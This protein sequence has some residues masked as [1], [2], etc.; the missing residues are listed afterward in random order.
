[1][2]KLVVNLDPQVNEVREQY[3][4]YYARQRELA[5]EQ[6]GGLMDDV[7]YEEGQLGE[8]FFDDAKEYIKTRYRK[9]PSILRAG[10][11]AA[12]R[13]GL[14]GLRGIAG[15]FAQGMNVREAAKKRLAGASSLLRTMMGGRRRRRA[16][17]G[18]R[19]GGINK[20]LLAKLKL[21]CS[22]RKR[23]RGRVTKRRRPRKVCRKRKTTRKGGC[24]KTTR[25]RR[26]TTKT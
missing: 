4:R 6:S 24:R 12:G 22:T 25:R 9:L 26:K 23:R 14:S 17:P 19:R 1:M 3:R 5:A 10:L 21:A 2:S 13:V 7:F 20:K 16:G 18:A 11:S 15:D 8:G